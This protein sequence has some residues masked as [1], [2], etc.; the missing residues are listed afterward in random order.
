M[1]DEVLIPRALGVEGA[2]MRRWLVTLKSKRGL[3]L[4]NVFIVA[5]DEQRAR[6]RVQ[7]MYLL[8]DIATISPFAGDMPEAQGLPRKR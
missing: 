2:S 1:D 5:Q 3:A 7:R 6:A 4:R 8:S